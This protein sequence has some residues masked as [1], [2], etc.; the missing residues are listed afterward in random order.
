M[1]PT[2]KTTAARSSQAIRQKK[3]AAEKT[4]MPP[5]PAKKQSRK[6]GSN[7]IMGLPP[8]SIALTVSKSDER[9]PFPL[10]DCSYQQSQIAGSQAG[11]TT[12]RQAKNNKI[13]GP[14]GEHALP[15]A[16]E[17]FDELG[18]PKNAGHWT[19]KIKAAASAIRQRLEVASSE[20]S[21]DEVN[22]KELADTAMAAVPPASSHKKKSKESNPISTAPANP[23]PAYG[24]A[25][26]P[27]HPPTLPPTS[28]KVQVR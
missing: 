4:D 27:P 12:R 2:T 15:T 14:T 23:L 25:T 22:W 24:G 17:V 13:R 3:G 20:G 1:V 6:R 11:P 10:T 21:L 16:R 28:D 26:P 19:K 5:P 9:F 8:S 7:S 18:F